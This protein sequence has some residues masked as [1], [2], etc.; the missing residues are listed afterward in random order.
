MA[1][2]PR[3]RTSGPLISVGQCLRGW[4]DPDTASD[5]IVVVLVVSIVSAFPCV[6]FVPLLEVGEP[7]RLRW[8]VVDET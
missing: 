2:Y 1:S 6:K 5:F 8:E 3:G 7:S 4:T